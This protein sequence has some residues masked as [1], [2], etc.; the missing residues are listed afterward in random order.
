M[1]LF[2]FR[3]ILVTLIKF[4]SNIYKLIISWEFSTGHT[5]ICWFEDFTLAYEQEAKGYKIMTQRELLRTVYT[6]RFLARYFF[7]CIFHCVFGFYR[8]KRRYEKTQ[9]KTKGMGSGPILSEKCCVINLLIKRSKK[10]Y[11]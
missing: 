8:I 5:R 4:Y 7:C 6:L 1:F 9:L 2:C 11:V 10:R 3:P